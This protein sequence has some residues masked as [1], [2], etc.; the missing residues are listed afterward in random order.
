MIRYFTLWLATLIL[1]ATSYAQSRDVYTVRGIPV[2]ERAASVI[3]AQQKAFD[4]AKFAGAQEMIARITLPEDR[5]SAMERLTITPEIA[6]RLAIAV[7]VEEEVRGAG[8]Y[9]G[10]LAVVFNPNTVRSLLSQ[11]GVPYTDQQGPKALLVPIAAD[12]PVMEFQ[13]AEGWPESSTGRLVPTVTAYGGAYGLDTPWEAFAGDLAATNARRVIFADL[14]G[15]SGAYRVRLSSLT[16]AGAM[17]I[18]T[19]NTMPSLEAA[20]MAAGDLLDLNW[21]RSAIVRDDGS[22]TM[23]RASV[24]YTSLA[25]WN[26]LRGALLRS[27]F[28]SN[29]RTEA[30]AREGAVV[31][32]LYTGTDE[33]FG[34]DLRQRGVSLQRTEI[35]WTLSS[36]ISGAR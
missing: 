30:V 6:D 32:F 8:R 3:E 11:A 15:V 21:K 10:Q 16:A 19:T 12:D 26:T 29:F 24:L 14:S 28:V 13:W 35:G 31:E 34:N 9:R 20:R 1:A 22:R 18:G 23:I 27:P 33:R 4:A 7:D 17:E 36:A 2:D 25:E 5:A